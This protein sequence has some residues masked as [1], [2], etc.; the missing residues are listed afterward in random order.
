MD[1]LIKSALASQT[2]YSY[3]TALVLVDP[4]ARV[5]VVVRWTVRR[6]P[7]PGTPILAYALKHFLNPQH[8]SPPAPSPRST[9][10]KLRGRPTRSTAEHIPI[11][12]GGS[13]AGWLASADA[14][15]P[16]EKDFAGAELPQIDVRWR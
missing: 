6:V 13:G 16:A 11:G 12:Y 9:P 10:R 5:L 1:Y 14:R 8:G 7:L 3:P 15:P 2:L 4:Q